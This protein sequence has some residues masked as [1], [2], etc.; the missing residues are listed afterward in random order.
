M[1]WRIGSESTYI[2]IDG[3]MQQTITAGI[4]HLMTVGP[5]PTFD[6]ETN[7]PVYLCEPLVVLYL[8]SFLSKYNRPNTMIETWITN[9]ARLT[10]DNSARG[11]VLEEAHISGPLK[12]VQGQGTHL[13]GSFRH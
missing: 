12:P 2:R 11:P 5:D 1:R 9:K 6:T 13:G 4:G 8:S 7:Y 10:S 3:N